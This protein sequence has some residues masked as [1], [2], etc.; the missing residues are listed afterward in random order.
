VT[1][2]GLPPRIIASAASASRTTCRPANVQRGRD[3]P[4]RYWGLDDR[5]GLGDQQDAAGHVGASVD[6]VAAS[7]VTC[8]RSTPR[9]AVVSTTVGTRVSGCA[10][11]GA[12]TQR[13]GAQA[14][15]PSLRPRPLRPPWRGCWPSRDDPTL[16]EAFAPDLEL[17]F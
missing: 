9:R 14:G 17:R 16:A 10:P 7:S 11:D 6:K 8:A 3:L 13:L 15:F 12:G 1:M 2:F 5:F 4:G